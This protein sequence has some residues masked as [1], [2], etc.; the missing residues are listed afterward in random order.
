MA[1]QVLFLLQMCMW[2]E[3][4]FARGDNTLLMQIYISLHD[5]NPKLF[6][7][8]LITSLAESS[9]PYCTQGKPTDST[10]AAVLL[11]YLLVYFK[12]NNIHAVA[13]FSVLSLC[14]R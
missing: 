6:L 10:I 13:S 5:P 8:K 11:N 2:R 3:L 7:S 14:Q 1:G 4:C 12:M 9:L